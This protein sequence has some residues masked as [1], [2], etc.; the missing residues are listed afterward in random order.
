MVS[1]LELKAYLT[2]HGTMTEEELARHF[3]TT[4]AMIAMMAERLEAKG[5]LKH[6]MVGKSSCCSGGCSCSASEKTKRA[7]QVVQQQ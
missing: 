4:P 7:W 2:E 1:S 3:E 5:T 6:F